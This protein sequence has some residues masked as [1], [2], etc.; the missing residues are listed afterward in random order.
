MRPVLLHLDE[1]LDH[2]PLLRERRGAM[3]DARDLGPA[4]R[5]WSRPKALSR[6]T[7]RLRRDLPTSAEADLIFAGSGDFHHVSPLLISRAIEAAGGKPLTVLHFDNHPDWVK[8]SNGMHCGSWVATAA[9]LPG[10]ARVITIGVC[11]GDIDHPET[12]RADMS[13]IADRRVELYPYLA[14]DGGPVYRVGDQNWPS[15]AAMGEAAFIE[16]LVSRIETDA[17]YVTVD[18]DVLRAE[19]AVTNWDQGRLSLDGLRTMIRAAAQRARIVGMD[20]V[21][22]WSPPRYGPDLLSAALKRGEAFLDQP[23]R[24]PSPDLAR[25]VNEAANLDLL[26]LFSEVAA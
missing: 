4:L 3:V 2:Q 6:L 22:D 10:V 7:E 20:V 21:G 12:K 17:V 1:A 18:K 19:D 24:G 11:S 8:F 13:L 26:D 25:Q 5:L 23:R 16:L 9:R 15:I 14:P